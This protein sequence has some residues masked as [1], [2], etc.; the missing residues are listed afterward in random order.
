MQVGNSDGGDRI[1][2]AEGVVW[3]DSCTDSSLHPVVQRHYRPS[4]RREGR[5]VGVRRGWIQR[6]GEV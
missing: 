2:T 1:F 3:L 5:L 6:H 4:E